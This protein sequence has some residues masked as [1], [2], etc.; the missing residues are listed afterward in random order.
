MAPSSELL[1]GRNRCSGILCS[2]VHLAWPANLCLPW[3][4]HTTS[5]TDTFPQL[6]TLSNRSGSALTHT[7]YSPNHPPSHPSQSSYGEKT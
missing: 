7:P 4:C 6:T 1:A 2:S 5:Q 3:D